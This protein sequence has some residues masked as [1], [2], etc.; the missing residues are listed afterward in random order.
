MIT[1]TPKGYAQVKN[2]LELVPKQAQRACELALDQTVR[3]MRTEVR[4][5]MTR[6]FDQPTRH[7]LNSLQV[8]LTQRHVLEASVWFKPP[9]RMGKHYLVP[10]VE[11]GTREYRGFER[12]LG[13]TYMMPGRGAKL[14]QHGNVTAGKIRQMLSVLGRAERAVGDSANITADSRKR[15]T[16][17]RDY[18]WITRRRGK[19]PPGV[20]ERYV[21]GEQL[22]R[23]QRRG[24][25]DK[26][27]AYQ[28]G[29]RRE[30][31]RARGLRSLFIEDKSRRIKPQLPFYEVA[32]KVADQRFELL[33]WSH[34]DRLIGGSR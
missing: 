32:G 34:F 10:Q 23:K 29:R 6:V 33:F 4:A 13:K 14:D 31:V 21:T 25:Q 22:T 17:V 11:G 18:V 1:V 3:D 19:L 24:V 8:S 15:N 9:D 30:V 20:Y 26:S 16:K 27:R 7:T 12:A 28:Q 2:M 5:T